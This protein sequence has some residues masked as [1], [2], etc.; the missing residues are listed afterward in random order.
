[1]QGESKNKYHGN[2]E[3]R[4]KSFAGL[5]AGV[6]NS[7]HVRNV[8]RDILT[9]NDDELKYYIRQMYDAKRIADEY[10]MRYIKL[11]EWLADLYVRLK[12]DEKLPDKEIYFNICRAMNRLIVQYPDPSFDWLTELLRTFLNQGN[13][14]LGEKI[15]QNK[16]TLTSKL[17][18][19]L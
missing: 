17:N 13:I 6:F 11:A 15:R 7:N 19:D 18:I 2:K 16:S 5:G 12:F 1:M 8:F 4:L 3:C 14:K 10:Q 9:Q